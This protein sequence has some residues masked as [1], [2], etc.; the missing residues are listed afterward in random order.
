MDSGDEGTLLKVCISSPLPTALISFE[1]PQE[2]QD[3]ALIAHIVALRAQ[4]PV[5]HFFDG[6]NTGH[7]QRSVQLIENED[8]ARILAKVC[9]D[10]VPPIS[11]ALELR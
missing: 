7:V 1:H 5:L 6:P 8:L 10:S 2:A 3:L 9:Y 4:V 11:V